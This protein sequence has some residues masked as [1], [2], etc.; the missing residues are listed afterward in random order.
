M[1]QILGKYNFANKIF[2]NALDN[3][4]NVISPYS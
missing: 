2:I 1:T 3:F 4:N